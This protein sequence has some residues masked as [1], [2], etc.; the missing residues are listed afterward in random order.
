[1]NAALRQYKVVLECI[2]LVPQVGLQCNTAEHA[3]AVKF[4][5]LTIFIYPVGCFMLNGCL[6]VMARKAIIEKRRTPLTRAISF[7]FEE[8]EPQWC[9]WELCEMGR[10]C[11]LVGFLVVGPFERGSMMQLAL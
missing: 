3:R 8:Y 11:V 1:M 2:I 6:I 7:L 4:A 9:G 10:R 5:W